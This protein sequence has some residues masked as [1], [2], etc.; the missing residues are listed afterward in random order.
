ML[1]WAMRYAIVPKPSKVSPFGGCQSGS[2][3][4]IIGERK[5]PPPEARVL[6]QRAKSARPWTAHAL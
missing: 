6:P 1:C 5:Q 3:I 4:D 2:I